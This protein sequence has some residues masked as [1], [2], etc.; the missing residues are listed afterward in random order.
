MLK[1]SNFVTEIQW[2]RVL[3]IVVGLA[4]DKLWLR[5]ECGFLL[6][7]ILPLLCSQRKE[8]AQT[9]LDKVLEPETGLLETSEGVAIWLEAQDQSCELKLPKKI[10]HH[11][12]V[13]SRKESAHLIRI[14]VKS[15]KESEGAHPPG[16][17]AM[18]R[19]HVHF[20]WDAILSRLLNPLDETK[21]K[22]LTFKQFWKA[23][24]DGWSYDA[25]K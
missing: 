19:P 17:K 2:S 16:P 14:I 18:W 6:Y 3:R 5:E 13:L 21:H 10:W 24:V 8:F 1:L 11:Q 23:A 9:L 25:R 12:A 7:R 15:S 20:V 4:R 22:L